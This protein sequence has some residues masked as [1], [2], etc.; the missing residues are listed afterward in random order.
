MSTEII[1]QLSKQCTKC[2][3]VKGL[4]KFYTLKTAKDGRRSA[5]KLCANQY[6]RDNQ[7][8]FSERLKQYQ[9]KNKERIRD[10][11][12]QYYKDNKE[13][14]KEK[15]KQYYIDNK[16]RINKYSKQYYSDNKDEI[17]DQKKQYHIDNREEE[18]KKSRQYHRDNKERLKQYRF[19]NREKISERSKQYRKTEVG[20]L[21]S[22]RASNKKRFLKSQ[23]N[24]GSIPLEVRHPLTKELQELLEY[25]E[26]KCNNCRCDITNEHHLDHHHPLSKGGHDVIGNVVFLCPACNLTKSAKMPDTLLLI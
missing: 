15:G 23:T 5:C 25:Q 8:R 16:E 22:I 6:T 3:E 4:D 11:K 9:T 12:K 7:E 19:D 1:P 20:R 14:I 21:A 13:G 17:C 24:D 26:Y 2:K 10:R 18:N